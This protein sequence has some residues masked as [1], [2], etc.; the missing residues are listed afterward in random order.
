MNLEPLSFKVT[1][2]FAAE[3]DMSWLKNVRP[4]LQESD[5]ELVSLQ[6]LNVILSM[7]A[8]MKTTPVGKNYY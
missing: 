1:I 7:A 6:A 8:V 2:K 4:G 3:L 5:K